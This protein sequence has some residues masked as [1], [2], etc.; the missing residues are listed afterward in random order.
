MTITKMNAFIEK[1]KSVFLS[2]HNCKLVWDK[3]E[4]GLG[5][6]IN[7]GVLLVLQRDQISVQTDVFN[8]YFPNVYNNVMSSSDGDLQKVLHVMNNLVLQQLHQIFESK[9]SKQH[10]NT[11]LATQKRSFYKYERLFSKD[12]QF[13]DGKY[14]FNYLLKN[15]KSINLQ[16]FHY[17]ADF[18]NIDST[19]DV[20]TI[21]Y[22]RKEYNIHLKHGYY[23]LSNLLSSLT[24]IINKETKGSFNINRCMI[25]NRVSISNMEQTCFGIKFS[26][27]EDPTS[28]KQML[29]FDKIEYVNNCMFVAESPPMLCDTRTLYIGILANDQFV[30]KYDT[31]NPGFDYFESVPIDPSN[32]NG[33]WVHINLSSTPFEFTSPTTISQ[34]SFQFFQHVPSVYRHQI[35]FEISL[36]LEYEN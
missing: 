12:A 15:V 31:S 20:F 17:Y 9:S 33:R 25:S 21:L 13:Q 29:G 4:E 7:D 32:T 10:D 19:S 6:G 16:D 3:L 18:Y 1:F 2:P 14:T 11:S 5:E 8:K 36:E 23:C 34:L 30:S 35:R 22:N 28:L 27:G 26:N 24:E